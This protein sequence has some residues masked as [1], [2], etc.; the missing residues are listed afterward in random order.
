M[1]ETVHCVRSALVVAREE[2]HPDVARYRLDRGADPLAHAPFALRRRATQLHVAEMLAAGIRV[3]ALDV[4]G[5]P[6]LYLAA[7]VGNLPAV[8]LL[9]SSG[10]KPSARSRNGD[11]ALDLAIESGHAEVARALRRAGGAGVIS[12]D[13]SKQQVR[14]LSG[15]RLY[16]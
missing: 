15:N 9:L 10:V 8:S 5:R 2:E 12:E 1:L 11:T 6:A 14:S 16:R 4:G 3:D 13:E 7:W